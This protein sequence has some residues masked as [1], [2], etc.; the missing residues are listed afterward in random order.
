VFPL[1]DLRPLGAPVFHYAVRVDELW[2]NG[3]R[4]QPSDGVVKPIYAVFDSGVTGCLVS[5]KLFYDSAF[6][7]GTYESHV[8]VR[9]EN[10]TRNS[11]G[12]YFPFTTF[13]RLIAH[14][15]LTLSFLS[16]QARRY[17]PAPGGVCFW[18]YRLTWS[19]WV[20][21]TVIFC[22]WGWRSCT[23]KAG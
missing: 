16:L 22:F 4:Y 10:G 20:S 14:T 5:K 9:D 15:I 3:G 19:G 13:R 17:R 6:Q 2:I 21:R 11:I 23:A 8:R 7:F 18:R 1:V 12:K